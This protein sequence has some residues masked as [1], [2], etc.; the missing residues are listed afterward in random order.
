ML[1]EEIWWERIPGA[2]RLRQKMQDI[3]LQDGRGVWLEGGAPWPGTFR[4]MIKD[5]MSNRDS[6][7]CFTFLGQEELGSLNPERLIFQMNPAA[8]MRYMPGQPLA[9]YIQANKLLETHIIWLQGLEA[10]RDKQWFA[11]SRELAGTRAGLRVIC[12]GEIGGKRYPNVNMLYHKD[13]FSEFDRILFAMMLA[14]GTGLPEN[15]Q[16][17]CSYMAAGLAGGDAE[18]IPPLVQ[19]KKNLALDPAGTAAALGIEGRDVGR[20]LHSVQLKILLPQ[21]ED[22]QEALMDELERGLRAML[23]FEDDYGNW[24]NDLYSIEL[25]HMYHFMTSGRLKMYPEQEERL[26]RLYALRNMIAHRKI[27][28]GEE[29]V[30]ALE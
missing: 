30:R 5:Y 10:E 12:Q 4:D 14:A 22:R 23:P 16:I 13:F 21:L 11:F 29:V 3:L 24:H 27:V 18:R 8:R 7:L 26:R 17:Y 28:L 20:V 1:P 2:V 19:A 25:R 15:L 9:K 6:R